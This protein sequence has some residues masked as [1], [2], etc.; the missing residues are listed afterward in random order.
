MSHVD[1]KKKAMSL[2]TFFFNIPVNFKMVPC[3][4]EETRHV[5]SFIFFPRV[6]RLY[7]A[8]RFEK[9]AMSPCQIKGLRAPN[10]PM[11]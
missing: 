3:R 7:V 11:S 5:M 1:F 10:L 8:C 2:V 9:L 6:T 4:F